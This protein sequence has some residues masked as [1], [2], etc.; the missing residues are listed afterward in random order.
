VTNLTQNRLGGVQFDPAALVVQGIST[1]EDP[2]RTKTVLEEKHN[3]RDVN[4]HATF[5]PPGRGATP[6]NLRQYLS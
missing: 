1:N 2:I 3:G 5:L 4:I 6:N